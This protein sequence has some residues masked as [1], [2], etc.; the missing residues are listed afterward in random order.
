[1]LAAQALHEDAVL[2]SG[3]VVFPGMGVDLIWN[4]AT[5]TVRA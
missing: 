5:A 3:D 2:I 4:E 1:M